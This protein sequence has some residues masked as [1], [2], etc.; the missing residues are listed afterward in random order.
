MNQ[1][2]K[3]KRYKKDIVSDYIISTK[4]AGI[5]I[6]E[7]FPIFHTQIS[8]IQGSN[9]YFRRSTSWEEAEKNHADALKWL[10]GHINK[11][12]VKVVDKIRFG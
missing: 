9:I 8:E 3:V 5:S 11:Y 4:L 10:D 7:P 12:D 6:P 2:D 1:D